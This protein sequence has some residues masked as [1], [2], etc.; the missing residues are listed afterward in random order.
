MDE[1]LTCPKCHQGFPAAYDGRPGPAK[2]NFEK[3]V[4][5]CDM[6]PEKW[7]RA[8]NEMDTAI[9]ARAANPDEPMDSELLLKAAGL[10]G[11]P[12][13]TEYLKYLFTIPERLEI[14]ASLS[15]NYL[16]RASLE[17]EL[18]HIRAQFKSDTT[19]LDADISDCARRLHS[20]YEMRNVECFMFLDREA[21]LAVIRRADT[22]EVVKTRAM[23]YSEMQR[24]LPMEESEEDL[25]SQEATPQGQEEEGAEAAG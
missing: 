4:E 15:G 11:A 6:T 25:P 13:V 24:D 19:K 17:E 23:N 8:Q 3:H 12:R 1:K 22:G 2:A 21:K 18:T 9:M 5:K 20:G 7:K 10:S 16:K 14:S